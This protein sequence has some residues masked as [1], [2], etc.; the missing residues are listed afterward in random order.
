MAILYRIE[1]PVGYLLDQWRE[2]L[3]REELASTE[4][5]KRWQ[6]SRAKAFAEAAQIVDAAERLRDEQQAEQDPDVAVSMRGIS[7]LLGDRLSRER[8]SW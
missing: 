6:R 8:G 5:D 2:S 3:K 4:R 7:E 1:D